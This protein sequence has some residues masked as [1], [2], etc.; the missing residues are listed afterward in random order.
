M[1]RLDGFGLLQELRSDPETQE[2]PVIV[3][4]ARAGEEA[5]I[6]GLG[7]GADDYLAKP[8]SGR[9]L[10]ARVRAN[11]ELSYARRQS[12]ADVR[13][14]RAMLEQTLTQLPVGVLLAEAPEDK[15][16][17]ANAE[18]GVIFGREGIRPEEIRPLIYQRMYLADRTTLVGQPGLLTRAMHNEVIEGL[19]LTFRRDDGRWR[20]VLASAA[21][22]VDEDGTVVAAVAVLEDISERVLTQ[23]LL[24][25]QRDVM[26]MIA[27]GEPL[28]T[29]LTEVV[30]VV[31]GIS[32]RGAM[33]SILLVSPDRQHLRGHCR[34][35][36]PR[37]LQQGDRWGPDR[38]GGRLLRH[39][40]LPAR[41]GARHGHPDGPALDGLPGAGC[42]ARSAR[43]L[44]DA[45]LRHRRSADW[46][47]RHLPLRA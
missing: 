15:I 6:Q 30:R 11:L 4:S 34:A 23:K 29:M 18:V 33:A 25:G 20:T 40:G 45:D 13:A 22:V 1:P 28:E 7:A 12:S 21:P 42:R 38:R 26:A 2:L 3:L 41:A 10:V 32:Q 9:E 47:L 24:A 44:V 16:V 27:R 5:S 31:E 46:H 17:L 36:P 8:F 19:E 37:G 39:C 14:E 35:K 43:L